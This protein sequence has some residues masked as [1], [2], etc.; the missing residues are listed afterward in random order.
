M[1]KQHILWSLVIGLLLLIP[2]CSG[3]NDSSG[4][5]ILDDSETIL[6]GCDTFALS[7][8]LR[9]GERIYT[10]PDSFLLGESET[11]FGT[12]HADVLTQFVCPEGFRYPDGAEVDSVCL[13][14]YY[15]SWYGDGYTPLSL[16]V[17]EMDGEVLRY[18]GV[19][20]STDSVS[21]FCSQSICVVDKPRIVVAAHP[22]DSVLNESTGKY[23]PYIRFKLSDAFRDRLFAIKDF[24][25]QD[26]FNEQF[27]GLFITSEFGG[28]TILHVP[29]ISMAVYYHYPYSLSG[30]T[31]V[32]T[33]TDI[34]GFYANTEVR[35][36]NHYE[37]INTQLEELNALDDS[38]DY[39][40]SP[41][42][43]FT[44]LKLPIGH[45]CDSILGA[46]GNKRTYINRAEISVEILNSEDLLD[47]EKYGWAN[48]SDYMLLIKEDAMERFFTSN[49]LPS[50]SCAL[51]QSVS[52]K[53]DSASVVHYYYT[54][55][56][57]ALLTRVLREKKAGTAVPD[58][59]SMVLV[60]VDVSTTMVSSSST[61]VTAVKH[62]QT[63]SATVV[64]SANVSS[65]PMQL[66]VVYSGF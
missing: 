21:R 3:D 2:S 63:I 13:F 53:Q 17:Y 28:A 50:D 19:Y 54:Y 6:V 24:S 8:G 51:L 55:D 27:K 61:S 14:I 36:I 4:A 58:T 23:M 31:E 37:L 11:L 56:L 52:T 65:E 25:N 29:E 64:R 16:N 41:G 5:E 57:S 1:N 35:Q 30:E 45:M 62:K 48:P 46:I 18:T 44:R 59:L 39:I 15:Q 47:W 26:R 43:I 32:R 42:Y 38:V 60:P 66:E 34:K 40:L 12:I 22:T 20:A 9:A 7:S 33:E 49:E 10:T